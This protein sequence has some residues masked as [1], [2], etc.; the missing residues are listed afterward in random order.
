M[1]DRISKRVV[2]V[3]FSTCALCGQAQKDG[4]KT[5]ECF[6][7]IVVDTDLGYGADS[8][9]T[10]IRVNFRIGKLFGQPEKAA[11]QT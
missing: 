8:T 7:H 9:R 5:A 11:G 10:C 6:P 2:A 1:L 4:G 3:V